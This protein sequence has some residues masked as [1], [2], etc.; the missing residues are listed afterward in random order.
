MKNKIN[1]ILVIIWMF[2]IFMM[3]SY[4]GNESSNQSGMIV[5]FI[6]NLLN[7]DN[8]NV[9]S[10]IIRK[11]AHFTEY[12]ILGL[13]VVNMINNYNNKSILISIII[14]IIY[15]TSDEIHQL[16]VP[17]RSCQLLDIL[18]DT[19]GSVI[20]IYLYKKILIRDTRK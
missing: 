8:I 13:L 19:I 9:L 15:A 18:I 20:G 10:L 14:C 4:D 12:L 16:F 6:A 3:S 1:I 11:M 17:G 5:N 2:I 7:I